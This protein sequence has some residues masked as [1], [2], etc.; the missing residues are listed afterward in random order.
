MRTIAISIDEASLAAVDRLAQAAGRRRGRRK[1]GN[2]SEVV[3]QAVQEFL[4]RRQ[5]RERED[6]D[7]RI[8][9]THRDEIERQAAALLAEQAEP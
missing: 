3:R 5:E 9:G 1:A 6:Q 4:S 7:R 2:R 8:L